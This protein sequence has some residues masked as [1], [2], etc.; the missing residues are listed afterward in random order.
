MSPAVRQVVVRSGDPRSGEGRALLGASHAYLSS[1]Y[2]PEHNHYLSIDE[3]AQ[4]HIDFW[5]A[6]VDGQPQ[7][8][9]AL[10]RMGD[11][12]EV[13][14]MFVDPAARGTGLGAALLAALEDRA[15]ASGLPV[16]RLETGDDLYPAHRLY[17]R[18][19]FTDCG[20]FG[21]YV[22]GPHSVFMEK[23]L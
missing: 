12:G 3:L 9:I 19:G 20:P 16:L 17:R 5:I 10:A 7:G 4:P 6:E 21:D 15:R 14:S 23:R 18:H 8:C 2:P 13:K 11:Y 22:E 1:L